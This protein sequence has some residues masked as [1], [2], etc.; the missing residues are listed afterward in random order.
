MAQAR[1]YPLVLGALLLLSSTSI[2][3][4]RALLQGEQVQGP[5]RGSQ[6][7]AQQQQQQHAPQNNGDPLA[8]LATLVSHG[9]QVRPDR[10]P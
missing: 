3:A 2:K 1:C 8:P 9:I 10:K 4:R 6:E 7:Q 5:P